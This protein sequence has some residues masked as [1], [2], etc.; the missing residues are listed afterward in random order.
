MSCTHREKGRAGGELTNEQIRSSFNLDIKRG[1]VVRLWMESGRRRFVCAV[2]RQ[3]LHACSIIQFNHKV[4]FAAFPPQ[5]RHVLSR[6]VGTYTGPSL[7]FFCRALLLFL[8]CV[9]CVLRWRCDTDESFPT[10]L[11]VPRMCADA[12][13][14]GNQAAS[15]LQ[16]SDPALKSV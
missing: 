11:L 2:R 8:L 4:I 16:K 9:S 3:N 10:K 12:S 14:D 13:A 15:P 5:A 6:V 1:R 7:F